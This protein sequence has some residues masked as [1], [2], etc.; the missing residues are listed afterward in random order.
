MG[1]DIAVASLTTR[2][3][4]DVATISIQRT[5][6][7]TR[8]VDGCL[9]GIIGKLELIW[10]AEGE[11]CGF[12][13]VLRCRGRIVDIRDSTHHGHR[14][15]AIDVAAHVSALDVDYGIVS[16][17]ARLRVVVFL[18]VFTRI[19]VRTTTSTKDVASVASILRILVLISE[20]PPRICRLGARNHICNTDGTAIDVHRGILSVM[21]VL[22]TTIDRAFDERSSVHGARTF[23]TDIHH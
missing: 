12:R 1:R 22:T 4:I 10:P 6:M 9:T 13:G 18:T 7:T 11:A 19:G 2:A 8:H 5:N 20:V 3:A 15:T 17:H 16:H 23:R 14:T 21:T